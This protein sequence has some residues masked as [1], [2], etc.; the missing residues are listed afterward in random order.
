M[1]SALGRDFSYV[2]GGLVN[3]VTFSLWGYVMD[4]LIG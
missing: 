4:A 2:G 3:V 1:G